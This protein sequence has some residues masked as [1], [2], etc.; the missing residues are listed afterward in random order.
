MGDGPRAVEGV[1]VTAGFWRGKRVLVT[2]HTGFKGGWLALWLQQLGADVTGIALP[3]PTDPSL[4]EAAHVA[5][6]M[7]S[8]TGDI[9][10]LAAVERAMRDHKPEVV[11]HL[12]A[13]A[14]V[15][16]SYADPVGTYATNVMG[17]VHVLEAAR[18]AGTV[19][20][21]VVVTSDKCYKNLEWPW[22]YREQDELGGRDPYSNSKS[23]AELVSDAYRQA[24]DG[25]AIATARAG[26][27]I[28][29]GDWAADRLVPDAVR[30][31]ARGAPLELRN[32]DAVRPWQHVLEPLGGYLLLAERLW[33]DRTAHAEAWNFGPAEDDSRPVAW[34]AEHVQRRFDPDGPKWR[35]AGGTQPH[36]ARTLRLDCAKARTRLGWQ[37]R[38]DISVALDWTVTWYR[39]HQ[40]GGDMR[41]LTLQQIAAFEALG[42]A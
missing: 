28:G 29:G 20:A 38:T 7:R 8:L 30:A 5:E 32:P 2:G 9:R 41:G 13:Q 26:N 17:T 18:R 31:A 25:P 40:D 4:F 23:C 42:G 22:G 35:Q 10:D 39:A 3:A 21:L 33:H 36:E 37:P 15:R 34:V 12:A 1:D 6:G 16:E 24:F 27:V 11:L 14:L 19:R